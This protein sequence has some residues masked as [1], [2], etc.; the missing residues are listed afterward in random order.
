MKTLTLNITDDFVGF[1]TVVCVAYSIGTQGQCVKRCVPSRGPFCGR[2]HAFW[3]EDN[4]YER[5]FNL[6][7]T[8]TPAIESTSQL[9]SSSFARLVRRAL[10]A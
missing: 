7:V 2:V 4:S 6:L 9:P 3:E 8:C 1:N 10:P 5:K